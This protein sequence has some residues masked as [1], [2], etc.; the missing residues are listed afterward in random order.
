[1][2]PTVELLHLAAGAANPRAWTQPFRRAL[3]EVGRLEVAEDGDR[4]S[5]AEAAARLRRCRILITSWG[6]RP[7]P[8]ELAADPGQLEY[9]CHLTGQMRDVVPLELVESAIPVTNWGDAQAAAVA[10]GAVTLLL[11]AVKGLRRRIEVVTAG[12]WQPQ[13]DHYSRTL[14]GLRV[15]IYG[16]GFIGRQFVGMLRGFGP[17]L[18]VYDPFV[19]EL[20]AGCRRAASLEELF[21]WSQAVAIHAGLTDQTRGSVSAALLARLPD[22]AIV[23]NTARGGIVD[24][25]ALF[26]ELARGRLLAGLDVLDG[27]DRLPADHPARRWPNLILSAHS[28]SRQYPEDFDNPDRELE[29]MHLICLDNLRR[30]LAG[31]PRRFAMDRERYLLST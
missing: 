11:A 17:E 21:G 10:E 15:G 24:Q 30:H 18:M 3:A 1:M 28:L 29:P 13:A 19:S 2:S 12:G 26:A 23:I 14:R 9:V 27:D 25:E 16:L 20:P 31:Q 5:D 8:A 22:N 4:L 6:A 7:V